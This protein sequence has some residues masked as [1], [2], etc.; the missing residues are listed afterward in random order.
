MGRVRGS[1][2]V[3]FRADETKLVRTQRHEASVVACLLFCFL[4]T[5]C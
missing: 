1:E 2:A 3:L 4:Y 5:T